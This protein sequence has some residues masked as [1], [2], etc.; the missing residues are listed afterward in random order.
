MKTKSMEITITAENS[1]ELDLFVP[2]TGRWFL[3]CDSEDRC[4]DSVVESIRNWM[5]CP[6]L[7]VQLFHADGRAIT[8]ELPS[9]GTFL[10]T[11]RIS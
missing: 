11:K 3:A 4:F 7:D 6:N 2:V 5:D 10:A 9:E 1:S 8:S